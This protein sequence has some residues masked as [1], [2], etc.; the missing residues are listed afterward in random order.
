MLLTADIGNTSITLGI[1]EEDA[2]VEEYR[3]ASDKDLSLEEYEVLLKSLFKDFKV[4]GCIISSVVEELTNKFKTAVN[5]VFKFEAIVLSTNINTGVEILLDNPNEA[6]ADRIANA[7]GAYVLYNHPVIVV[8]FGTATT[9]DIVNAKG[10]FIGGVIAPGVT[11]QLKAL[12]KFTSKLPRIDVTLSNFAIGHNTTDAI[13]SGVLRGSAAMIDGLVEQC[14][15]ELGQRAVLVAT[16]G[17]SGLIANYLKRPF[18]FINPTLT[19]EGLRYLYQINKLN[20]V[21]KLQKVTH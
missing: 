5:N 18:D 1:F 20:I 14:E 19:L 15:K 8:D 3:L 13:L 9:F 21:S 10:Q 4:D 2:L 6:G 16:G 12:N 7:A 17:Y 11:L